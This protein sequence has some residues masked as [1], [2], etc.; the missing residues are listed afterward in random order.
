MENQKT[1]QYLGLY[2][3]AI[4][5]LKE[6]EGKLVELSESLQYKVQPHFKENFNRT[7]IGGL[8]KIYANPA[9]TRDLPTFR[10]NELVFEQQHAANFLASNDVLVMFDDAASE[11]EQLQAEHQDQEREYESIQSVLLAKNADGSRSSKALPK[12]A[13]EKEA[14]GNK[15]K[16]LIDRA[17]SRIA[18]LRAWIKE[19]AEK[20]SDAIK[21]AQEAGTKVWEFVQKQFKNA[22]IALE[23]IQ[24]IADSE[25]VSTENKAPELQIAP[26]TELPT[27]TE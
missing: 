9:L 24:K 4:E 18:E 25:I 2:D 26:A 27:T 23:I 21:R 1:P 17:K 22:H 6:C 3:K 8:Q 13:K 15:L 20:V 5:L 14:R 12:D 19:N 10:Q 16:E 11:L 7:F